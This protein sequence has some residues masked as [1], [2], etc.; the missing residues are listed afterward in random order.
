MTKFQGR[1]FALPAVARQSSEHGCGM[2]KFQD[3]NF[4][5]PTAARQGAAQGGAA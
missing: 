4:A 5:P 2:T 3:R 1:N